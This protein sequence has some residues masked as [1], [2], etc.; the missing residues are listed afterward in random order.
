MAS[1]SS[2]HKRRTPLPTTAKSSPTHTRTR[3]HMK[4]HTTTAQDARDGV[5]GRAEGGGGGWGGV[6]HVAGAE[7]SHRRR[8][9]EA[10]VEGFDVSV[11]GRGLDDDEGVVSL[12]ENVCL[13]VVPNTRF[14]SVLALREAGCEV[15]KAGLLAAVSTGDVSQCTLYLD[16]G[17]PIDCVDGRGMTPLHHSCGRGHLETVRL[18][19]DRGSTAIDEKGRVRGGCTRWPCAAMSTTETMMDI[20]RSGTSADPTG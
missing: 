3:T 8:T 2:I 4:P 16:A 20:P 19:L 12:S 10:G 17:V 11:G 15:S 6:P 13:D 1:K 14:L 18:L 9:A 7:G 5:S